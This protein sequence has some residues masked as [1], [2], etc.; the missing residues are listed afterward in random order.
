MK[1]SNTDKYLCIGVKKSCKGNV[2]EKHS[3]R[4][5]IPHPYNFCNDPS[6]SWYQ[7]S[8][9]FTV[10]LIEATIVIL[11]YQDC[12]TIVWRFDPRSNSY[13]ILR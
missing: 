4:S 1:P 9:L 2:N 3:R 7:D 5:K 6:V 10:E 11:F 13:S 12:K 8:P